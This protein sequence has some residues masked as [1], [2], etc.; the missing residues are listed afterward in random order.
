MGL[1][2]MD[3]FKEWASDYDA[4]VTGHDEQYREVFAGYET[5]LSEVVDQLEG[6]V[7]EFGSGTGNL[8]AKILE[9]HELIPVEPSPEMRAIAA[10]KLQLDIV[11]GDFLNYPTNQSIDTIVSSYAFHHLTDDEK[12][13][14][15]RS[16]V[17]RLDAPRFVLLDTMFAS[18]SAK[19][20][21][22]DWAETNGYTDLLEDLNREFYPYTQTIQAMLE[23][24][25]YT[26]TL[27]QKNK[28]VWLVVA[29][30]Q[31]GGTQS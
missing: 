26:V 5:M 3:I 29:T 9:R 17:E 18:Q 23:A 20:D 1:Q 14:A 28:F 11:D 30:K 25:G 15:I 24:N 16:Y 10:E 2:F 13:T 21:I 8:S 7:M 6:R 12:R 22:L 4:T 19:R 31:S 27:T